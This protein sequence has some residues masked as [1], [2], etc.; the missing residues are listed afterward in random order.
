MNKKYVLVVIVI[1]IFAVMQTSMMPYMLILNNTP[2]LLLVFL[3]IMA[4]FRGNMAG[5]F[6]GLIGGVILDILIG[7]SIGFYG[8][9]FMTAC[10]AMGFFPRKSIKDSLLITLMMTASIVVPAKLII[11]FL[12]K[13]VAFFASGMEVFSA[14]LGVALTRK[15]LPSLLYDLIII[16]PVYYLCKGLDGFLDKDK[17][18]IGGRF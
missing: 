9:I 14:E 2:D 11:Y 13:M 4:Y 6:L 3:C 1:I 16:V 18:L 7:R 8:L 5:M 12:N 17:K 10:F 15:I